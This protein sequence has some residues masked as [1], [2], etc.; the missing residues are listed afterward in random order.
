MALV[1]QCDRCGR[2]Y[3][4]KIVKIGKHEANAVGL[5]RRSYDNRSVSLSKIVDL[6]PVCLVELDIWLSRPEPKTFNEIRVSNGL[7][8]IDDLDEVITKKYTE[9]SY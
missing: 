7:P 2:P 3:E 5:A 6:C 8:K 1:K 4:D 9:E